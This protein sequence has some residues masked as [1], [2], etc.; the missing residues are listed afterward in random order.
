MGRIARTDA[1]LGFAAALNLCLVAPAGAEGRLHNLCGWSVR[2]P[3][4]AFD[5]LSKQSK[6]R[7]IERTQEYISFHDQ[8]AGRVWTFTVAG[9]P[10]HPT[11]ICRYATSDGSGQSTLQMNVV[12]G[13]PKPICDEL[14]R[15]F[16][17]LNRETIEKVSKQK[18]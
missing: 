1:A 10:A 12:C 18:R 11:A 16:R 14:V 8:A 3:Q 13:G 6:V 4:E 15:E 5:R 17:E 2:S 9:H 7:E